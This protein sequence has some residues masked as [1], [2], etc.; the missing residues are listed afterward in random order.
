MSLRQE[1]RT[2]NR[3]LLVLA[4]L[5][6]AQL[7]LSIGGL[8]VDD[9]VLIGDPIWLKPFKFAVSI[10]VY[11]TTLAWM[12]SLLRK[13]KRVVAVMVWVTV[14]A[15]VLEMI[16]LVLQTIRGVPSHFNASP[17]FDGFVF[18]MMGNAIAALWVANVVIAVM[19]VRQ[20]V[21]DA[22]MRWAIRIGL[23]LALIGM[24]VAFLMPAPT[25][26]QLELLRNDIEPGM[27]GAH[28]VGVPDGGPGMPITGWSTVG[29][30]LRIPHFI[31]IHAMQV[32]PLLAL[33]LRRR[34]GAE[35]VRTRLVLIGGLFYTG[36]LAL[37]LWQALRGQSLIAPDGLTLGALA[38]L[39]IGSAGAGAAAIRTKEKALV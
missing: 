25:P 39:V 1:V 14:A 35:Q 28:S 32:L 33:F 29:G 21:L 4:G 3:P 22:P 19:L 15:M 13:G 12:V 5:A 31:G 24:A 30:D 18:S 7:V 36:L 20:R 37:L 23:V 27:I 10:A 26:E 6:L 11:A 38:V 34:F 16:A 9:R 2:W 17:G 8:V